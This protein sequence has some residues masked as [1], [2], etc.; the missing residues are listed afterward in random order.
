MTYKK[1]TLLLLTWLLIGS[2]LAAQ[3]TDT[4]KPKW[5]IGTDLL[6]LINKNTL[7]EYSLLVRRQIG[8]KG[9]L[10]SRIGIATSEANRSIP[11]LWDKGNY[12]IRIGYERHK[13]LEKNLIAY[14]G[15][16]LHY[17]YSKKILE[18]PVFNN[19]LTPLYLNEFLGAQGN[20]LTSATRAIG[21]IG[22]V[23]FRYKL[24]NY[25]SVSAESNLNVYGG[26]QSL[27]VPFPFYKSYTYVGYHEITI[28]PISTIN[29][30]FHL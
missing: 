5:E 4:D 9:A 30:S 12:M 15:L 14:Y 19:W 25:L 3:T 23:G 20:Y 22:V 24:S 2:N 29:F 27:D 11:R 18:S 7:P 8:E 6:W 16:D 10:R 21:L 1:T 26:R 28:S 13:Q 17:S